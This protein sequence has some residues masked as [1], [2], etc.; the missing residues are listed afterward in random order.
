MLWSLFGQFP[1]C[2]PN[3]SAVVVSLLQI[4]FTP[5]TLTKEFRRVGGVYWA[6]ATLLQDV[7]ETEPP[8]HFLLIT[9]DAGNSNR[10]SAFLRSVF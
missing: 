9:A 10:R 1:N 7:L 8:G 2:R 5:P 6:L 4:V 3:P